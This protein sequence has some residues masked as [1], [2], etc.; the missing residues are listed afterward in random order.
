M[1]AAVLVLAA[2][3]VLYVLSGVDPLIAGASM[4]LSLQYGSLLNGAAVRLFIYAGVLLAGCVICLIL[5][6]RQ[7]EAKAD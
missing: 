5:Y 6:R 1:G 3:C 7:Y 4:S 2:C